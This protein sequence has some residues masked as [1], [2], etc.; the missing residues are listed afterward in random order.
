[1][2]VDMWGWGAAGCGEEFWQCGAVR[3]RDWRYVGQLCETTHKS[4]TSKADMYIC[5]TKQIV[6]VQKCT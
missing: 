4:N 3:M 5:G 1:M 2:A 6:G